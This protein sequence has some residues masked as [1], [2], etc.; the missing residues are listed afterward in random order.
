MNKTLIALLLFS[1]TV[2]S[3]NQVSTTT[4]S[5]TID[6]RINEPAW[7]QATKIN[8]A[9]EIEPLV[10]QKAAVETTALLLDTGHSLLIAFDAKDPNPN[11]ITAFLHDRDAA[12]QDDQVGVL[13]DTYNDERR[14]L[15]FF[16]NPLG[17]QI[18]F[19]RSSSGEDDSWDAIWESKGRI[20]ESGYQ[21]EFEIP[22]NEIQMASGSGP[23]TWG[24]F[25]QRIYPRSTRQILQNTIN[26]RNNNCFLCQSEKFIGFESVNQSSNKKDLDL[27]I[28]PSLTATSSKSRPEANLP[29][30]SSSSDFEPSLDVNW[31]INSNLTLNA[32]LNPDFSQVETDSGQLTTNDTFAP[33]VDEKRAFF[34]ENNDVFDSQFNLVHTRNITAPEYGIRMVGKSGDNAYGF[35]ITDDE[36]TNILIPGV[37]GSSFASL[38]ESSTNAVARYRREWGAA[39]NTGFISTYRAAGDYEN[40]VVSIDNN[41][42]INNN[43]RLTAQWAH[44]ETQYTQEIINEYDQPEGQFSGDAQYLRY[45][46]TDNHWN[47]SSTYIKRDSGFRAD[48]GFMGQIGF[49]K[50]VAGLG[51]TW[52]SQDRWWT[53]IRFYTDWDITHDETGQLLE[54]ELEGNIHIHGPLQSHI[55][56]GGGYRD[57]YW[58]GVIYDEKFSW[59]DLDFKPWKNIRTQFNI[60]SGDLVDYSN[61]RLSDSI[62]YRAGIDANLG[63]HFKINF[64]HT[65][66]KLSHKGRNVFVANQSDVRLSYQFNIKQ[67][68]RLAVIKT[69]VNRHL[70][71]YITPS[72]FY[73][74]SNHIAT[75]LVYSYKL[76]PRS[77]MYVGYSDSGYNDDDI[78][79]FT[80]TDKSLFAKFSYAFKR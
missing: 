10:N 30:A 32:T 79:S 35:F 72:D 7:K 38:D 50:K 21:V 40:H 41:Y 43:N 19:I 39:S 75:Q 4:E 23:K 11:N 52:F 36:Q 13:L 2:W 68:L 16:V 63:Q 45:Q 12:Y 31:G 64:N 26:D 77:L 65:H 25:A 59:F 37:F 29:Y 9:Y 62:R 76:N 67:R 47:I 27:E 60:N 3:E 66:R 14:A 15:G 61:D 44:S 28:T 34:L 57:R 18:D 24:I 42:R 80:R 56:I 46:Y 70:D 53:D 49:D 6:G 48:S 55:E 33:F 5:I 71:Q 78:E 69:Q 74:H 1:H 51:Y 20:T 17:V 22:Y 73:A 54:K 58:E 8:L